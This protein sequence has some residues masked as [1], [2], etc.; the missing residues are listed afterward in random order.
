MT[1]G[2]FKGCFSASVND[3]SDAVRCLH[4]EMRLRSTAQ[5]FHTTEVPI[6]EFK[7]IP[8]TQTMDCCSCFK[9]SEHPMNFS[10]HMGP[11]V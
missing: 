10:A 11:T 4:A 9:V 2:R 8:A 7:S 1:C 5:A 3:F 6:H